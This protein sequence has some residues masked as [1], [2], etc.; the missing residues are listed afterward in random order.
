LIA[1]CQHADAWLEEA[2]KHN[3]QMSI[4]KWLKERTAA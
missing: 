4:D 1:M 3:Q 2:K